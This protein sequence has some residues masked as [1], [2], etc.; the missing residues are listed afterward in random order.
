[1]AFSRMEHLARHIR[2]HTGEKPFKCDVCLKCFSR[3]DNLKQHRL[4][5]HLK[6]INMAELPPTSIDFIHKQDSVKI[7]TTPS[8]SHENANA[9]ASTIPYHNDNNIGRA[10]PSLPI[11][12]IF[13]TNIGNRLIRQRP[14]LLPPVN[15]SNQPAPINV[16]SRH[17]PLKLSYTMNPDFQ[18]RNNNNNNVSNSTVPPNAP[19]PPP[20]APPTVTTSEKKETPVSPKLTRESRLSVDYII[21]DDG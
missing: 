2:K 20:Q 10:V 5:V 15:I 8:Y 17:S 21:S 1:M 3:L 18:S 9:S 14:Y 16:I 12:T 7:P 4:S 19:P 11:T 13:P 6:I